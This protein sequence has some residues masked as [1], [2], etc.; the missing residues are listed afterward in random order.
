MGLW[1][2]DDSQTLWLATH[3]QLWRLENVV[4]PGQFYEDHDRL[5][6]PRAGYTTGDL[7]THDLAVES[8]GRVVFVNTRFGC[9]ATL[10]QRD[11]FSPLWRPAF[12]SRLLPEDRCHLNGLALDQGKA[13]YVTAVSTSD[14]TDGWRDHR[15]DGGIVIDARGD[16]VVA[17]GLSMPHSPRVYRGQLWLHNSGTGEFGVL[18]HNSGR[19]EPVCFGPGY[20]RGLAFAG[21]FAIM[22]LSKPR[23]DDR[24]FGG[25]ELGANL[26]ARG[27]EPRC[28]F[29]IVDIRTGETVH[30]IRIEG[31]VSELYDVVALPGVVRPMA[32]GFKTDEIHRSVTIGSAGRL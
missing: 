22:G 6:I 2:S 11:S 26:A 5:Y 19:F 9:L 32:F 14:V 18:E 23:H 1:A 7:D 15:R 31:M 20:L 8:D 24:A 27:A 12:Q 30:W 29:L 13:R 16:E 25:L 21:D 4:A 3:Y 17:R 28:G 10:S